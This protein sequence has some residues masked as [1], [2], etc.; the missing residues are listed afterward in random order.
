MVLA[1]GGA[2]R[3]IPESVENAVKYRGDQPRPRIVI[4]GEERG[5]EVHCYVR[6]NGLGVEP[7]ITNGFFGLHQLDPSCEGNGV[8]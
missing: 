4:G 6:D 7:N 8:G 1:T 2:W 5:G 3:G